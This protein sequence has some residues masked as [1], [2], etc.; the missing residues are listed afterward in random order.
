MRFCN[1]ANPHETVVYPTNTLF[2]NEIHAN[3]FTVNHNSRLTGSACQNLKTTQCGRIDQVILKIFKKG[4][5][6]IKQSFSFLKLA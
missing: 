5:V 1:F 6:Y 4:T 3:K 2:D